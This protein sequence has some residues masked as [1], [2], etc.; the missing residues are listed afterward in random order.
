MNIK[1][2]ILDQ[3]DLKTETIEIKEWQD[4]KG[5]PLKIKIRQMDGETNDAWGGQLYDNDGNLINKNLR[6]RF[7]AQHIVD[8]KGNLLFTDKKDIDALGKKSSVI[9]QKIYN[10]CMA[11]TKSAEDVEDLAKN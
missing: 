7:I 8:D 4:E 5:I 2:L 6:A 10:A 1:N 3:I 11:L 9:L